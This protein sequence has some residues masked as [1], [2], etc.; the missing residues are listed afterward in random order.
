M[1]DNSIGWYDFQI[2]LIDSNIILM[3]L[4]NFQE[5]SK[6]LMLD[7]EKVRVLFIEK[8]VGST[9]SEIAKSSEIGPG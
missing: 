1:T 3:E 4:I 2:P 7:Q 5:A 9:P 6:I 8:N